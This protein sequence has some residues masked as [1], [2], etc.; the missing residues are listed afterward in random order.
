[1]LYKLV[2]FFILFRLADSLC[3]NLCASCKSDNITCLSCIAP[4]TYI[5]SSSTCQ[6][7]NTNCTSCAQDGSCLGCITGLQPL[8]NNDGTISCVP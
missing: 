6:Y 5:P 3:P 2:P 4:H 1:M 8:R 7:C